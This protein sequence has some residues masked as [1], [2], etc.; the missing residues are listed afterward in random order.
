M[1]YMMNLIV[2]ML[3]SCMFRDASDAIIVQLV[4]RNIVDNQVHM[5]MVKSY[6]K[7]LYP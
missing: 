4:S 3:V 6:F 1:T 5:K 2:R 7:G